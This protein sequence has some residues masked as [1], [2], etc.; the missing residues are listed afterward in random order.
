MNRKLV[1]FDLDGTVWDWKGIIPNSTK[2]AILKLK[3]NGHIPIICT[4]RARGHV[5]YESL[6]QIGFPGMVVACGAHVEYEGKILYENYLPQDMV[7]DIVN[8]SVECRVPIVLEGANKHWVSPKGFERDSFVDR[9][10]DEMGD[11]IVYFEKYTDDM[12][13]NKFAGD[14]LVGSDYEAF[15]DGLVENL[16]WIEHD[17]GWES[18]QYDGDDKNL[19][20]GVFEGLPIG[21]SKANGIRIMCE[22]LGVDPKDTYG[23]GD[24]KNDIDM[25]EYVGTGIA[26]GDGAEA[27]KNVADYVTTPLWEDGIYK[28]L[29]HFGLIN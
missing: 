6:E 2:E 29:I 1:F 19:V 10:V 16:F 13:V 9:M 12:E 28:A 24:S 22:Y 14:V 26:M 8:R 21:D 20:I 23:F 5:Y 3:A 17:N 18:M 7:R 15:K 27:L 11:R 4:G 25:I